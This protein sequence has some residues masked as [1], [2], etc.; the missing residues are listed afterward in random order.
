MGSVDSGSMMKQNI[1]VAEKC[2]DLLTSQQPGR[3]GKEE[4]RGRRGEG[5]GGGE[6]SLG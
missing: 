1:M 4:E 6:E 2:S 3:R 5:R